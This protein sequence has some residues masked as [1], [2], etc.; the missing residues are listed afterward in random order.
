MWS[1]GGGIGRG[2]TG[3]AG[4]KGATGWVRV[5]V[6]PAAGRMRALRARGNLIEAVEA[7]FPGCEVIL[8]ERAGHARDLAAEASGA[9]MV[10]A[11]G[12]DGTL[13]EVAEG[14]AGGRAALGILPVGTG[15]DFART[16][17]IPRDVAA[18]LAIL[19]EGKRKR[20]DL[21]RIGS[22]LFLNVAG[23]GF[24][25][26][27]ARAYHAGRKFGSPALTYVIYVLRTIS[28]F[29]PVEME[30]DTGDSSFRQRALFAVVGN[31]RHYAGGMAITPRA[32]LDD[33]LLD[34]MIAGDLSPAETLR[35]LPG[36]FRGAHLRHPKCSYRQ[37]TRVAIGARRPVPVMADGEV[38][39]TTPVEVSVLPSALEVV[40]PEASL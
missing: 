15:N 21:A 10:V 4:V 30:F 5:I 33:G 12:G 37:V 27:V 22:R 11:A 23:V 8:T 16:V 39:G 34:L 29:R 38:I 2:S 28:S 1:E 14:L 32:E 25:A 17:R 3:V 19:R 36:V 6:N 24:D 40:V 31:A 20:I 13:G 9:D 35:A 7:A 18:A 26:E